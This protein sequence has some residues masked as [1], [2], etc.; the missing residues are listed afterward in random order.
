MAV[1]TLS[2]YRLKNK[3]IPTDVTFTSPCGKKFV[4]LLSKPSEDI[5]QYYVIDF[6]WESCEQAKITPLA[7]F[8]SSKK[9]GNIKQ[10]SYQ[11]KSCSLSD[12]SRTIEH[13]LNQFIRSIS[14]STHFSIACS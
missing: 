7:H 8:L 3:S 1:E 13:E 11:P 6:F 5:T 14:K 10:V 4:L 9:T 12:N 2:L